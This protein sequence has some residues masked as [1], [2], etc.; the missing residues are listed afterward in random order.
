MRQRLFAS[1]TAI[2]VLLALSC[3]RGEDT[4]PV[5]G[6]ASQAT[7]TGTPIPATPIEAVVATP[8]ATEPTTAAPTSTASPTP[9]PVPTATAAPAHTPPPVTIIGPLLVFSER[10]ALPDV[11]TG[12]RGDSWRVYVY[13]LGLGVY[14]AALDYQKTAQSSV[15]IAGPEL[16]VWSEGRVRRV[17]LNGNVEATLLEQDGIESV[18]VSPDGEK[19]AV[20]LV[21][22]PRSILVL[23][24]DNGE[25]L[26]RVA[27]A[28][29]RL[30]PLREAASGSAL[31]LGT[32][33]R[34]SA[35][36]SVVG[37]QRTALLPLAGELLM[38]PGDW[39]V[40]PD[41]HYAMRL[42]ESAEGVCLNRH[43]CR[44][45]WESFDVIEV[46]TGDVLWTVRGAEGRGLT[47]YSEDYA[48]G[49][50]RP[51]GPGW[52]GEPRFVAFREVSGGAKMV[53][54]A[55]GEIHPLQSSRNSLPREVRGLLEGGAWSNCR[56]GDGWRSSPC[57]VWY[58]ERVVWEGAS[59]WTHY[60]GFIDSRSG[61]T[62]D[63]VTAMEVRPEPPVADPPARDKMVGPVLLYAV[64]GGPTYVAEDEAPA[65]FALLS[66]VEAVATW[67]VMALDGGTGR[68]WLALQDQHHF[69]WWGFS[70][71]NWSSRV[72][73]AR[74]GLVTGAPEGLRYITLD[75]QS[76]VLLTDDWPSEF[77]VSPDGLKV[78]ARFYGGGIG[79]D[80]GYN[81][82]RTVV[83]DLAS[84]GEIL[85]VVHDEVP[86]S[87]GLPPA[88]AYWSVYLD[89]WARDSNAIVFHAVDEYMGYG[90]PATG[91]IG[92]LDGSLHVIPCLVGDYSWSPSCYAPDGRHVARG[93]ATETGEDT[94]WNWRYIDI[95]D[96]DTEDVVWSV[97][98][99]DLLGEQDWE[100]ASAD[101]FAWSSALLPRVYTSVFSPDARRG[102]HADVTVLDVRTGETEVLDIDEYLERFHPPPRATADCPE[103]PGHSC[104]ILLDGEVVGEGRWPTIIGF[105]DLD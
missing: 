35:R 47:W 4:A 6:V 76:E 100:W 86:T 94:Q 12:T 85:R 65:E 101:H 13:D 105:V 41:L 5:P 61:S 93:R 52:S 34:D 21:G 51:T 64:W 92:R 58:D 25:E 87:V 3:D 70:W 72:Q 81:P 44:P 56:G 8:V 46:A 50:W 33:S 36:F 37:G 2:L 97:E 19:V 57:Q 40:S 102:K 82:A 74:E 26:L 66:D 90:G 77:L 89:A 31:T 80:G 39:D 63:G 78:A 71:G 9:A 88:Q 91:V 98:S 60:I 29:S 53:D 16:I 62:L 14:W 83:F 1:L 104:R 103:N 32:W 49:W 43:D 55:T 73:G 68:S 27:S 10:L 79:P 15:Q 54:A 20:M 30:A 84:G 69:S 59:A 99:S 18:R 95:L 23:D 11:A 42:G 28:D 75:A 24:T 45:A 22:G 96:F 67:D 48:D 38:V 7:S 17:N